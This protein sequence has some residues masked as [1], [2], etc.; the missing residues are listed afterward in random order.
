M[1]SCLILNTEN[2]S[3]V[4]ILPEGFSTFECK[5]CSRINVLVTNGLENISFK[6]K[7]CSREISIANQENVNHEIKV[8]NA[9]SDPLALEEVKENHIENYI[10]HGQKGKQFVDAETLDEQTSD[11]Q[12]SDEKTS[13][14]QTSDEQT[15][16]EQTSDEE[17][18]L[19]IKIP[20]D[21][22]MPNETKFDKSNR[23]EKVA[24]K[25]IENLGT[26]SRMKYLFQCIVC[27]KEFE[28]KEHINKHLATVHE[29]KKLTNKCSWILKCTICLGGFSSIPS[30]TRHLALTHQENKSIDSMKYGRY[31]NVILA[32]G[33]NLCKAKFGKKWEYM[34]HTR[35]VHKGKRFKC[36]LC[37]TVFEHNSNYKKHNEILHKEVKSYVCNICAKI[38]NNC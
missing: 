2:T 29:G 25:I 14:E 36:G 35:S 30:I 4:P 12:T 1:E 24:Q 19:E 11:E 18:E 20:S 28:T 16:D 8:L 26:K 7:G 9:D 33:C 15:S 31:N 37:N 17:F 23:K 34:D 32:H 5:L 21:L 3:E 13:D 22:E 6:C 10:Q 38:M 27:S